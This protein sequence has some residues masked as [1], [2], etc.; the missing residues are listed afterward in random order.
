MGISGLDSALSGLRISQQQ[1]EVI[2]GNVANAGTE[3]YTRKILP[4]S[5]LAANGETIG[6]SA[7]AI[8]RNVDVTLQREIWTQVSGTTALEVK[9][10]YMDD[11]QNFYGAP[12]AERTFAARIATLRDKFSVLTDSPND[13]FLLRDTV[14]AA[15][16]TAKEI[17]NYAQYLT[18]LRNDTQD[19]IAAT[20][21]RINDALDQIRNFN[22]QIKSN[23]NVGKSVAGLR[24][25]RDAAVKR[26][27]EDI[28]ISFFENGSGVL[29]VQTARGEFLVGEETSELYFRKSAI[30]PS[31]TYPD[32]VNAVYLGG[33]PVNNPQALDITTTTTGG[34]LGAL[35]ELRD[36]TFPQ[37]NAEIDELAHKLA[38][39]FE[40]QGLTLFVN[41]SGEIPADTAPTTPDPGPAVAVPY[42]GFA[43]SIRVVDSIVSDPS[44]LRTGTVRL[45][46]TPLS[47]TNDVIRR[48]A[49][50]V[51]GDVS[52]QRAAGTVDVVVSG[53]GAAT[54]TLG[55]AFGL[56]PS[57]TITSTRNLDTISNLFNDPATP[58]Q[59]PIANPDQVFTIDVGGTTFN[60]DLV[61]ITG[62]PYTNADLDDLITLINA[63]AV[64][65]GLNAAT[66]SASK[67]TYGQLTFTA[68]ADV[69]LGSTGTTPDGLFEYLTI[70]EGLHE[71]EDPYFEVQVGNA[72]PVRVTIEVG[73]TEVELLDKLN[74][75]FSGGDTV[76]VPNLD[77]DID[78]VTG[79][80]TVR[81][82][83]YFGGDIKLISGPILSTGGNSVIEE[84]FGSTN[85][86]T[87][88]FY[89]SAV[90]SADA[91]TVTFRS[92]HLGP[93]ANLSTGL[94]N[95][96][97]LIDFA[98][99]I[100]SQQSQE[101][102][103][104]DTRLADEQ[105]Y[106]NALE[107]QFRNESGVNIDEE[108]SNLIVIQ[109]SYAASAR[110]VDVIRQMF[111]ELFSVLR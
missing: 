18:R 28:D 3:N 26:L 94:D 15:V 96:T 60:V 42:V 91:S 51:F 49:E 99:K 102:S 17:R 75:A 54:D 65:A 98:Q 43:S 67:N 80:L 45:D 69:T 8:I 97:N 104:I 30:G 61:D 108:L 106:A 48:V 86:V 87:N 88:V 105:N 50:F 41:S 103:L 84:L 72:N 74:L 77:A 95:P 16:D 7:G 27:S 23:Q 109:T 85:P 31:S 70:D 39:R 52:Y 47:G 92:D 59:D 57:L 38:L 110:T 4:Q 6:V 81:P 13:A 89:G 56:L 29:V 10:A 34:R 58:M 32:S 79:F 111:D 40:A 83:P 11:V 35:L 107:T 62:A 21:T 82:G 19:D 66:F 44:I 71:A 33:N 53:N 55:E 76:G 101:A 63:N 24:D 90:S 22:V 25:L 20:V 68:T 37:L 78:G 73:D 5:T 36:E 1:L 14:N 64:T 46:Q 93:G 2:S 9:A 100:L 12:D